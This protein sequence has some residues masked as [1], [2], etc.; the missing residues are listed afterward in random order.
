ML[1]AFNR[2]QGR[3]AR[4]GRDGAS[5]GVG[6]G[7]ERDLLSAASIRRAA[8]DLAPDMGKEPYRPRKEKGP[9]GP[10]KMRKRPA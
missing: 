2:V 1:V 7:S 9:E 6:A 10:I 3:W 5:R 4:A 8:V